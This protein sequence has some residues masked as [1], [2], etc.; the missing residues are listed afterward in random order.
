[1]F[2]SNAQTNVCDG[3][4]C[5]DRTMDEALTARTMR[6]G[7]RMPSADRNRVGFPYKISMAVTL[8]CPKCQAS[9]ELR[10]MM[11]AWYRTRWPD[12]EGPRRDGMWTL[13]ETEAPDA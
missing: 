5:E 2:H 13:F 11:D 1:M 9:T 6:A 8:I 7:L 3:S 10:G 4:S 12:C